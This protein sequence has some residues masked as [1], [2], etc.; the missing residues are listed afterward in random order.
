MPGGADEDTCIKC[1]DRF[2]MFY[3]QTA[4]RLTRTSVW[5]DK[6]EGGIEYLRDARRLEHAFHSGLRFDASDA[7]WRRG[8]ET[9][10]IG[11]DTNGLTVMVMNLTPK[12]ALTLHYYPRHRPSQRRISLRKDFSRWRTRSYSLRE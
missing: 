5:L 9:H 7:E 3:T 10:R 12:A 11:R 2:L 6:L 4:D 8:R 1:I